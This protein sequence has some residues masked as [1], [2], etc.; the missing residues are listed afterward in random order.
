MG[1]EPRD[2][3]AGCGHPQILKQDLPS[4]KGRLARPLL[5]FMFFFCM[6]AFGYFLI[7]LL[8]GNP[9][10]SVRNCI[11]Q[12][13]ILLTGVGFSDV[14]ESNTTWVGALYTSCLAFLGL[15][16][17]M[18]FISTI[19]AF[20]VSGEL[21]QI[22]E[23]K[24]MLKEIA[25]LDNH[26]IICGVGETGRH[27]VSELIEI[28]RPFV[29]IDTHQDRLE[30]LRA[31]SE[32]PYLVADASDDDVLAAAGIGRAQGLIST[33]PA[34]KD[35]LLVVI[36]ARQMNPGLRIISRCVELENKKK[37]MKAGANS[38]VAPNMI[39]GLRMVSEMVRP[40]V[41][42]FLDTMMRDRRA[43]RF[44]DILIPAGHPLVGKTLAEAKFPKI[45]D[46]NII[47]ARENLA[48]EFT[49]NPHGDLTLKAGMCLIAVGDPAGISKL[50]A[51]MAVQA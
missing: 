12:T 45:A 39:G 46:I 3:E 1:Q 18:Y 49:Y 10:P 51:H 2:N 33:L 25:A 40:T 22:L 44:E 50:R 13:A 47:A 35:N 5:L 19:T 23:K 8:N 26:F 48:A 30:K 42:T 38:I 27:I 31:L 32:F 41:V 14:L 28:K 20:I 34:D 7:D 16:F 37:L 43:I 21:S 11:Y 36:T 15:G 6:G 24:K 29:A 9:R 17:L 4:L